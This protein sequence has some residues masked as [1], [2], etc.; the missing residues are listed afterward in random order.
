MEKNYSKELFFAIVFYMIK[1]IILNR[2]TLIESYFCCKPCLVDLCS[3]LSPLSFLQLHKAQNW[4]EAKI[5]PAFC[6]AGL[7]QKALQNV[8]PLIR[9]YT[10]FF[11]F[12]R[13]AGYPW[14]MAH[15]EAHY[16]AF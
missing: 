9:E 6:R 11:F 8:D 5:L 13:T 7:F 12:P 4:T 2:I 3:P 14:V 15:L 10:F 16:W 1:T